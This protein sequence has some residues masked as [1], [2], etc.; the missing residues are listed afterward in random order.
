MRIVVLFWFFFLC[1][2]A[3]GQD[4]NLL[5]TSRVGSDVSELVKSRLSPELHAVNELKG[6][7][8]G[9][10]V[11]DKESNGIV[12]ARAAV[13]VAA[14][15]NNS[16]F[17]VKAV[18][19]GIAAAGEGAVELE[20][21]RLVFTYDE[22]K[23]P[24]EAQLL[25]A[26]FTLSKKGGGKSVVDL[27]KHGGTMIVESINGPIGPAALKKALGLSVAYVAPQYPVRR[28]PGPRAEIDAKPAAVDDGKGPKNPEMGLIQ[29]ASAPF[30]IDLNPAGVPSSS[31]VRPNDS[32]YDRLWGMEEIRAPRAWSKRTEANEIVVAVFDTGVDYNHIDLNS[33]IWR[34]PGEIPNDG[35]D[36]DNNGY[37]DDVFG[38]DFIAGDADPLDE[39]SHGTHCAGTIGAIGNGP[40]GP[41]GSAGVAG[42]CWQVKI[43][44]VRIL[45]TQYNLSFNDAECV[46]YAVDNGA[47]VL[48]NSW[49]SFGHY[50]DGLKRAIDYAKDHNVLYVAAA[51]NENKDNDS[52]PHYPPSYSNDNV[53]AVGALDKR[54]AKASFS[55]WGRASVDFFAPGTDIWSTV[56]GNRLASMNG[57]SMACPHVAGAAAL[58]W[59]E[60]GES[61]K[62]SDVKRFL[63]DNARSL[64]SL[65]GLCVTSGTMD[66]SSFGSIRSTDPPI[67]DGGPDGSLQ[68]RDGQP[69]LL[70]VKELRKLAAEIENDLLRQ[71]QAASQKSN[72]D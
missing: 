10:S 53:I 3:S 7:F 44:S 56:P 33:N 15:G 65:N 66:L 59:A 42:V 25:D 34:N 2:F 41:S 67:V 21:P 36:N 23:K 70:K 6:T 63:L 9:F 26:G 19:V 29:P 37:V 60:I 52:T 28:M 47:N 40:S 16:F 20:K 31:E 24:S 49:T 45:G 61:A 43:M 38:Y 27:G 48:S 12:S 5:V 64:P 55:N 51:S 54:L 18:P 17:S 30:R 8:Q 32:D 58:I 62:W 71:Q 57:T 68:P 39:D 1:D 14:A 13:G 22:G 69:L 11:S 46:K 4:V 72:R 50:S 35:I